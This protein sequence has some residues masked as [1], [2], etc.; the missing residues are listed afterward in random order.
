MQSRV[1][2][3]PA[4]KKIDFCQFRDG[5]TVCNC[6]SPRTFPPRFTSRANALTR[7]N[8]ANR[9]RQRARGMRLITVDGQDDSEVV[10]MFILFQ[11]TPIINWLMIRYVCNLN[12]C[13]RICPSTSS[14]TP[15]FHPTGN[16]ELQARESEQSNFYNFFTSSFQKAIGPFF[17][18]RSG[19][20]CT[21]IHPG[22]S[23]WR[24][25]REKSCWSGWIGWLSMEDI[26]TMVLCHVLR[27]AQRLGWDC[28]IS[29]E[30]GR[31]LKHIAEY[32]FLYVFVCFYSPD[33]TRS[34]N[35]RVRTLRLCG[36]LQI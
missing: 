10:G 9:L 16:Q 12:W 26:H 3:C 21:T 11:K 6:K 13:T 32:R 25:R 5:Q 2:V 8:L 22:S 7:S 17:K 33:L 20:Q 31:F 29:T 15:S 28:K 36:D 30:A 27:V 19:I 18:C 1:K 14:K 4:T 35:W 24:W 34:I 23:T